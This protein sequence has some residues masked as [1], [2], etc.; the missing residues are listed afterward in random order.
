MKYLIINLLA[1]IIVF[2]QLPHTDTAASQ[3][4]CNCSGLWAASGKP[5]Y[6]GPNFVPDKIAAPNG[7]FMVRASKGGLSL[8]GQKSITQLDNLMP[9]PSLMEVLWSP[10]SGSFIINVSDGGLVGSWETYFYRIDQHGK[11]VSR[12]IEGLVRPVANSFQQCDPC[13]EVNIGTAAAWINNGREL[14]VIAQVPPHSSCRNMG[15]ILGFRISVA[16]W[17][18][19]ER[20][21]ED[22][23]RAEW[24]NVL[25]CLAMSCH[26]PA[27][28]LQQEKSSGRP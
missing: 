8:V 24:G 20:I 26:S 2:A 16:S 17:R 28:K 25:G 6:V 27:P 18:I 15:D 21:P 19:I 11:P 12:D 13:E 1:T 22:R 7:K 9:N 3:D 23:L 14:L 10:D 5:L 4:S